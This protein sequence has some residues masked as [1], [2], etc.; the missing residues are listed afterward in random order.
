M[1]GKTTLL[2]PVQQLSEDDALAITACLVSKS[3]RQQNL[4][5]YIHTCARTHTH[6]HTHTNAYTHAHVRAHTQKLPRSLPWQEASCPRVHLSCIHESKA[7]S[8]LFPC[9]ETSPS[10][11]ALLSQYRAYCEP[12]YMRSV[13]KK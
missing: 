11:H 2:L 9:S 1:L 7:S 5:V 12:S 6:T 4:A 3:S 8:C 10:L 13:H